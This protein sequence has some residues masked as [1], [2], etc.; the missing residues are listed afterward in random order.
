MSAGFFGWFTAEEACLLLLHLEF[1][2]KSLCCNNKRACISQEVSIHTPGMLPE[3]TK[4]ARDDAQLS[5]SNATN[6]K[7]GISIK[8]YTECPNIPKLG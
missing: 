2:V 7:F 8:P 5:N 4:D 1:V 6:G 3:T